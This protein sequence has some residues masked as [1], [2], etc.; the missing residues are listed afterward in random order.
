MPRL[1]VRVLADKCVLDQMTGAA[2]A[3]GQPC[4]L[5]SVRGGF[6]ARRPC[7]NLP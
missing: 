1:C 7:V 5:R 2:S 3:G 4:T 6:C